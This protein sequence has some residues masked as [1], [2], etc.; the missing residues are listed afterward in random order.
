MKSKILTVCCLSGIIAYLFLADNIYAKT[1]IKQPHPDDYIPFALSI[2]GGISLGSYE[3]GLNWAILKYLRVR[4]TTLK[5]NNK[6]HPELM[7]VSGASAGSINAL[8]SSLLWCVDDN[9]RDLRTG[10][11]VLDDSIHSNLFSDLW[12]NIGIDELLPAIDAKNAYYDSDGLLSRKGFDKIIARLKILLD[13]KIFRNDCQIPMGMTVTR[14]KPAS[15]DIAG[16]KVKNQRFMI[17]VRF[18]SNGGGGL[19][20]VSH[21]ISKAD[22]Y[23]GNVIYLKGKYDELIKEYI[24]SKEDLINA[25]LTSSAFPI[26]FGRKDLEYCWTEKPSPDNKASSQHCP[27]HNYLYKDEFLDG[28]VFDNVPLGTAK[29]LAEQRQFE[30]NSQQAYRRYNYIYL[31]PDNRRGI[32]SSANNHQDSDKES[33]CEKITPKTYGVAC[34]LRFLGG[35]ISTS[36]TYELYNT[37]RGPDW[38]NQV[39]SYACT[40]QNLVYSKTTSGKCL[41]RQHVSTQQCQKIFSAPAL[42]SQAS[43]EIFATCLLKEAG[44]LEKFYTTTDSKEQTGQKRKGKKYNQLRNLLIIRMS[45]LAKAI[46]EIALAYSIHEAEKDKLGDRRLLLSRRF[47]PITG[48]MLSNFGA[49]MDRPFREYDYF[50]GVYDAMHGIAHYYCERIEAYKRCFPQMLQR[51]YSDLKIHGSDVANSMF[52]LFFC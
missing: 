1:R 26:A 28:G 6:T 3:A 32:Y 4:R 22:P 19:R 39:F 50:A 47:P 2:S 15:M 29:V 16:V 31:E 44:K 14:V 37:L 20:V 23:L 9:A 21:I 45:R 25:V 17:P 24:I 42:H 5:N 40:L 12:L 49:F 46:D 30:L 10:K 8:I 43:R 11:L 7:S 51:V 52:V 34:Q 38:S 35:A 27:E 18:E 41:P 36:R 33:N 48:A 13:A